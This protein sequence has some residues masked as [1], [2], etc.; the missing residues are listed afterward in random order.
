MRPW[1]R[2]RGVFC[3]LAVLNYICV[4]DRPHFNSQMTKGLAAVLK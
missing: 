2:S 4:S 1:E 3:K